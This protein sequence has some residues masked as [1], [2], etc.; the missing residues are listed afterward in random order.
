MG[1]DD[2][3][4]SVAKEDSC[5][6]CNGDNSGATRITDTLIGSGGCGYHIAGVIPAGTTDVKIAEAISTPFVF[7]GKVIHNV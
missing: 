3:L 2:I 7:I 1:C 4:K 5:G 6:V